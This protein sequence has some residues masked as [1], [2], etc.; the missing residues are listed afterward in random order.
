MP[1]YSISEEHG[2]ANVPRDSTAILSVGISTE[3]MAECRMATSNPNCRVIATTLDIEGLELA[4]RHIRNEQLE[5]RIL[6]KIED[7]SKPA[8]YPDGNFDYIYARLVLHYLNKQELASA[9]SELHRITKN[10]GSIYIVVRSVECPAYR[11]PTSTHDEMSGITTY[12]TSKGE[13]VRQRYFHTEHSIST[14]L[15]LANFKITHVKQYEETLSLDFDRSV[16][17]DYDDNLIE[18]LAKKL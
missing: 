13:H 7:V 8:P 16:L 3:G 6:V 11:R 18:V 17:L 9:L 10:G 14:A 5:D 12:I 15:D 2:L 1:H 4:E